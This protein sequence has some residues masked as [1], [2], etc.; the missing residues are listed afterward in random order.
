MK[1]TGGKYKNRTIEAL[2]DKDLR[3][4]SARNREVIFNLLMHGRFMKHPDFVRDDNP[5]LVEG[6][7]V[8]DIFCGTGALG[9]EAL[10]R[11]AAQL[12]LVDQN[13]TTLSQARQN[14][15]R[16]GEEKNVNFI[17]SDS[18]RLPKATLPCS[19]AFMD[20]PYDKGLASP[21]LESLATQGWLTE[22]AIVIVELGKRDGC[23]IPAGY[24]TLDD[25]AHDRTRLL[26]LQYHGV[27]DSKAVGEENSRLAAEAN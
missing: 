20:P 1:I 15:V 26:V 8:I 3:P 18:T 21:A 12:I 7:R 14:I 10:S 19:L 24:V 23:K 22:T 9:I 16:I 5:S 2:E 25:R 27:K 6:R 4:T 11:G 17:R 13:A